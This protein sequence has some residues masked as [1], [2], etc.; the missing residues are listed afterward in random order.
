MISGIKIGQESAS[1][2][3]IDQESAQ[4]W[5]EY[6]LQDVS[7]GDKRLDWRLRDTAA[8]L[9]AR[10]HGSINR[11]CEDWADT[12]AVYRLFDNEKT[13][14]EKIRSPHYKRTRERVAAHEIALAIQDTTYLDY[15]HH[16]KKQG[17]GPLGTERQ[18]NLRGM[19]MHAT[20]MTTTSGLPLGIASQSIWSRGEE[21][22][23]LTPAERRRLPIEEKES[24]K[25]LTALTETVE[26]MPAGTQ[27]VTVG[28]SESDI[29]ELFNHAIHEL[30]TD[31]LVRAGQ[32]R[33]VVEPE[34]G[35][36]NAL[37]AS[38]EIAGY[39]TVQ[40]PRQNQQPKRK[41][42]VTVRHSRIVLRAP[43]YLRKRMPN[44]P[45]Y[46]VLVQEENPPE[47]VEALSWLLLT[48][49]PVLS[50]EDAVE[51]I[52]WY[53]QRWQIEVYHKI[54]KSGCQVE[55]SQLATA[56]RLLPLIAL[57]SIIAWRLFWITHIS[58]HDP[59]APCTV[60]LTNHE[61]RA[62]YAFTHKHDLPPAQTPTVRDAVRWIAQLGGFLA[63]RHDGEPG[64]TVIWRGWRRLS[65]IS[66][67]WLIFHPQ[68]TCG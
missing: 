19:V 29:F 60:I 1:E 25:W 61:W 63:R 40:V 56:E 3:K 33:S 43:Q 47:G 7:L 37:I 22:K 4:E 38:R 17:I 51:R 52:Q 2:I 8:K 27:I 20:L 54:L 58:R 23:Q 62:L 48:T 67:S 14:P 24:Y 35:R 12:K 65:D 59:E 46:A 39:L 28:D 10:P 49:V 21:R 42:I 26:L 15:S 41:A 66:A 53:R 45:I 6:E 16:P 13:T 18:K 30:H 11:V 34:V 9:I 57:F 64:V 5:S 36:I 32:D 31:L 50:L 44:L 55:K 68:D